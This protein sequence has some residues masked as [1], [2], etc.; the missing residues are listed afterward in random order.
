MTTEEILAWVE[1]DTRIAEGELPAPSTIVAALRC[2]PSADVEFLQQKARDVRIGS[3]KKNITRRANV[4]ELACAQRIARIARL[5]NL[6]VKKCSGALSQRTAAATAAQMQAII[7]AKK[8]RDEEIRRLAAIAEEAELQAARDAALAAVANRKKARAERNR[9][10]YA[11]FL[12]EGRKRRT[13]QQAYANG[14]FIPVDDDDSP[15]MRS[16]TGHRIGARQ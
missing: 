9:A 14:D 15:P 16:S 13:L 2:L 5:G 3:G 11:L 6:P 10:Q 7:D 1:T 8:A 4:V 12:A